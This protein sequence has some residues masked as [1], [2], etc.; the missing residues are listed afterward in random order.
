MNNLR[1][2]GTILG[3]LGFGFAAKVL[4]NFVHE[5]TKTSE[6][7]SNIKLLNSAKDT[8]RAAA[9]AFLQKY[10]TTPKHAETHKEIVLEYGGINQLVE[11]LSNASITHTQQELVDALSIINACVSSSY[12]RHKALKSSK[13]IEVI[14][15]LLFNPSPLVYNISAVTLA[16][17]CEFDS[18]AREFDTE[19]PQGSE[20]C[21]RLYNVLRTRKAPM[22]ELITR[23]MAVN[24]AS[25][26]DGVMAA[27]AGASYYEPFARLL[28]MEDSMSL[29]LNYVSNASLKSQNSVIVTISNMLLFD[30]EKHIGLFIQESGVGKQLQLTKALNLM[31]QKITPEARIAVL[32]IVHTVVDYLRRSR[33]EAVERSRVVVGQL[34]LEHPTTPFLF[35][36]KD[37]QAQLSHLAYKLASQLIS[38]LERFPGKYGE[39]FAAMHAESR[40]RIAQQ[41][42]AEERH[43]NQMM[44]SQM[45]GF[46]K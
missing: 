7:R 33:S 41:R 13:L 31:A 1:R 42:A 44:M 18:K 20:G 34:L 45:M 4:Y 8:D 17:L 22:N 3:L 12:S 36:M 38:E 14:Y 32:Q 29:L 16:K 5:R 43:M 46:M 28:S 30:T 23:L 11:M 6:I 19:V 2:E 39:S 26:T 21:E 10:I 25:F 27:L 15:T 35:D 9:I 37:S 24:S 40:G